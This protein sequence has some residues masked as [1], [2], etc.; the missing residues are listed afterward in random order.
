MILGF[1]ADE[2]WRFTDPKNG[3]ADVVERIFEALT[4]REEAGSRSQIA[5]LT[6]ARWPW[7]GETVD[8]DNHL[9]VSVNK[10]TGFGALT[11]Y[12]MQGWPK[13]GDIYEQIWVTDNPQPPN[14]DP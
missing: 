9:F 1:R 8:T 11:W 2:D 7:E 14:F 3:I 5:E 4:A 13:E 12:V 10:E 6:F